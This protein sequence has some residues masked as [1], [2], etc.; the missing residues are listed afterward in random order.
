MIVKSVRFMCAMMATCFASYPVL[1][2]PQ[3]ELPVQAQ[4]LMS[5]H[6]GLRVFMDE[7]NDGRI[8]SF[9]GRPMAQGAS[10]RLS[11]EQFRVKHAAALG[12]SATDLKPDSYLADR[13]HL[14]PLMYD[15]ATGTYKMTAVYYRQY[16]GNIPVF[17]ADVR[18]LVRNEPNFPLV[19]VSNGTRP[20]GE[21]QTDGIVAADAFDV[22]VTEARR[23]HPEFSDAVSISAPEKTIWV[24]YHEPEQPRFAIQFELYEKA[25]YQGWLFLADAKTGEIIYEENLSHDVDVQGNIGGIGTDGTAADICEPHSLYGLPYA[26]VS[27]SNGTSTFADVNGDF[28]I[29]DQP[30]G[31]SLTSEIRGE[32]FRV[33]NAQGAEAS[34][35]TGVPGSGEVNIVHN[36]AD[37][38]ILRAQVD[39]YIHSNIVRDHLLD[40]NPAYPQI[41]TETE[42]EVNVNQT[43]GICPNNAQYISAGP[44]TNYCLSSGGGPNM[45][46]SVV[47]YH[48]YGH[49]IVQV[50][51]SG[52][53]QYGEGMSDAIGVLVTD[54]SGTGFGFLGD[55]NNP[56]RDADNNCAYSSSSCTSNCGGPCHSCGRLISGCVWDTRT[57]LMATNPATYRDIIGSLTLNSVLLHGFTSSITPQIAV[58]FLMLDDDDGNINNGTP[59]YSEICQA[60]NS[61]NMT[62]PELEAFFFE[63]PQGL[64]ESI[65]PD[66]TNPVNV[67]I[68]VIS[69]N[70]V[71]G[72]AQLAYRFNE[73]GSYT[74]VSM[75][76]TGTDE[77]QALL[78]ATP[79]GD[80]LEYFFQAEVNGGGTVTDPPSATTNGGYLAL[81]ATDLVNEATFDFE[82]DNGWTSTGG[83]IGAWERDVPITNCIRGNPL[84]DYDG[85][86]ACWITENDP[87]DCNS[88]VDDDPT[89][90]TSPI[91]DLS[92]MTDPRVSYAR[93]YSNVE[94]G[95]PEADEMEIDVSNNGGSSWTSLE[96]IGPSGPE[97]QGGWIVASHR[98]ADVIALTD[99]MRFR[100]IVNDEGAGS[101]VEGGLDDFRINDVVCTPAEAPPLVSDQPDDAA[102]CE[103]GTTQFDV[104]AVGSGPI[105]YQWFKD[106]V[107]IPLATFAVY[108]I[109]NADEADEGVYHCEAT[110]AF[111]TTASDPA[112]LNVVTA[113]ECDDTNACT[114]DTCNVDQC[115]NTD[116]TPSDQCCNPDNGDLQ[117]VSDG[118]ACTNDVC[119]PSGSVDHIENYDIATQCCNPADGAVLS[120]SDDNS[121]TD[122]SCDPGN[123]SVAHVDNYDAGTECCNPANGSVEGI[124]DGDD[125]TADVC[126]PASGEVT[127]T[128]A[129]P[130]AAG[131]GPRVVTATPE[132]CADLV[133]LLV[134]SDDYPC[135]ALYVDEFGNLGETPVYQSPAVWTTVSLRSDSLVPESSY[136]LQTESETGVL[137]DAVSVQTWVWGD[138]NNNSFVNFEDIQLVVNVF[139]GDTSN[140][141]VDA[142][143]LDPCTPNATVNLADAQRAVQAFQQVGYDE[144]GCPIP[145][146]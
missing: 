72:T 10:A 89:T 125:C 138:V 62:C 63:Y 83:A 142:T 13:R 93:W 9:Y 22:A 33:F 78:P 120:I 100:F 70:P 145:C 91:F 75:T 119:N 46:W 144:S 51:G 68:E 114:M 58:D 56:L 135:L 99:Q 6:P 85:S 11:A 108:F 124:D 28:L 60:F 115:V 131:V 118:N 102:I 101:V 61:H 21:F 134:T 15:K 103:S 42:F 17:R 76:E 88:D 40:I 20:I 39:A 133:A 19:M 31:L 74:F 43:G 59:H 38:E 57:N 95:S 30:S 86:G 24:G 143:D 55:C 111:G 29:P 82:A 45:A 109:A 96:I 25:A 110:N 5:E 66:Q 94:G 34:L 140:A 12:V 117:S 32:W 107:A 53:C 128:V 106:D 122:D 14:Q 127:H 54:E 69:G 79:C 64:P 50:G 97:V 92:A 84:A 87:A 48:E 126:A 37:G 49:H 141:S 121:C 113:V 136:T 73:S 3:V 104:Q 105:T 80:T 18:M 130:Q 90:L 137:S 35:T 52:Q 16:F 8:S 44:S 2:A 1:A 4:S 7:K 116:M 81:A 26:L 146:N 112:V 27:L 123:G 65:P 132:A 139:Q 98:I 129:T 77:Y 47:V 67:S 23:L 71:P 36:F 41:G